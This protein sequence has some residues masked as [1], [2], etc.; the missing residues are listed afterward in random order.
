MT[1][2][3]LEPVG[4]DDPELEATLIEAHLP[5]DDI[6]DDGRS[7]FRAVAEYG[8]TVGYSGI[9]ACGDAGLLR[10][11][12]VL[13]DHR[14][15]GFGRILTRLTLDRAEGAVDIYLATTTASEFFK[16]LGFA[17]VDRSAVP[18]AVLSTRQ[19]SGICP[20]SATVMK[21]IRPAT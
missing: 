8:A 7:F 14:G 19:L 4:G 15:K 1:A 6:R 12:V 9:E 16:D 18:G 3:R 5:T 21:L 17:V 13:P 11:L 20:A 10:S 2:I